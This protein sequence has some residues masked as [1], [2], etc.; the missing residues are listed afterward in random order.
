MVQF[1]FGVAEASPESLRACLNDKV[2]LSV[3][4]VERGKHGDVLVYEAQNGLPWTVG[5]IY[6]YIAYLGPERPLV[7]TAGAYPIK[8]GL[9]PGTARQLRA[10]FGR[11]LPEGA[12]PRDVVLEL[13]DVADH[14]RQFLV[15]DG[16][17]VVGWPETR[18]TQECSG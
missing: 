10:R 5:A 11:K 15:G 16:P 9:A 17:A 1:S 7:R 8:E 18:T 12:R 6:V 14:E 13:R 2:T 4:D 3:L